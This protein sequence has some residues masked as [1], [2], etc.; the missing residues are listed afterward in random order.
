MDSKIDSTI[1]DGT[2]SRSIEIGLRVIGV[3]PD[4][5]Y[6][7]LRRAFWMITLTIAQTF[8]YRY[9]VAHVRTEDLSHLMDGLSTTM[10]YS[11]LLLKLTIFW[12]NRRIFHGILTIMARDRSECASDWAACSMSRMIYVS[13]RSSNLIIGLY[14]MSVFLYGT[15][16]LVAHADEIDDEGDDVQLAVP[17]RELF[18]KMELPFESN[19]SPV[20]EIVMVTQFF[21]QLAAATIVGVLNALIVSLILHVGG[22]IDI[23]C[24]GLVEI[25][26]DIDAFDLRTTTVKALIHRHQ[27]IIALSADI[28]TLFSYIALM[29]F[30]WNTLVICCLG[31][32]IVT[33]FQYRYAIVHFGQEDLTLLMDALSVTFAYTL[34]LIKMIIFALNTRL[35]NEI[36]VRM[37]KDWE[38]CDILDRYTMIRM[39]YISRRFSNII[40]FSHTISVFF[41]ATGA[42]LKQKGDNQTDARELI[43]KMELPF[44]VERTPIYVTVLITQFL[45][46]SSAAAMVGVL[47]SFLITLVL[48]ACG[49]IDIVRQKFSEI[50]QKSVTEGIMKTLIVRHQRI[51]VFS[52]NIEALFSNIALI[53]FV[54]NTLVICCLGF[55]IVISI[56]VP[57]GSMTL[58]KS[59]FFYI[60]MSLEAFIYCF[61]GEHLSTKNLSCVSERIDRRCSVRIKLV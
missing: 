25:S 8:Q 41:Y 38:E 28:E 57:G 49:Q 43:V 47:N 40:I 18:L 19:A 58:V 29:Q 11:L 46:Q 20:Y 35:L 61:V 21:H 42:L 51:I 30:L 16:V 1:L 59:V 50:T 60:V 10:S 27:R 2:V 45:H 23:M 6:A 17:A 37:V 4:S 53:Q 52:K 12:I 13:H 44:E 14:S 3:W 56:G 33:I 31:F 26:S 34:L 36:I 32:L 24:R 15:G 22:Q 55:L 5:S 54:S 9:F 39:A 48:H 7:F